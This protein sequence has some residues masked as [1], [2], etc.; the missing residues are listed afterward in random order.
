M[1][2]DCGRRAPVRRRDG[3][4]RRRPAWPV[5]D[6][7]GRGDDGRGGRD[8]PHLLALAS[9]AT[10]ASASLNAFAA[11]PTVLRRDAHEDVFGAAFGVLHEDVE[12]P[13]R[14]P[15]CFAATAPHDKSCRAGTTMSPPYSQT[16]LSMLTEWG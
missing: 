8:V 14:S 2:G 15:I 13:S 11:W 6:R 3:S 12:V 5:R 16:P 9:G 4:R 7:H 1:A 10:A